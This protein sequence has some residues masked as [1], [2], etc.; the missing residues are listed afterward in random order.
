MTQLTPPQAFHEAQRLIRMGDYPRAAGLTQQLVQNIPDEPAIRGLHGIASARMGLVE[1]GLELLTEACEKATDEKVRPFLLI[2]KAAALRALNRPQD[3]LEACE[4]AKAIDP[5]RPEAIAATAECLIDLGRFD[6]A[7]ALVGSRAENEQPVVVAARARLG[8]LSGKPE[9][10]ADDLAATCE[11]V[12]VA[13]EDLERMLRLLG[14]VRE[15]QGRYD[16]ALKSYKR[17]TKLRRGEFDPR[18]HHAMVN[19]LIANWTPA[20]VGKIQRSSVDGSRAVFLLGVPGAGQEVAEQIIA[21]HPQGFGGGAMLTLPRVAR[22][23]LGAQPKSFRHVVAKPNMLKG[24]QLT[25]GGQGYMARL[26]EYG[27]Q[28]DRVTDSNVLNLYLAGLIPLMLAGTNIVFCTREPAE[29]AFEWWTS[30]PG[31]T[32]PYAQ[33]PTDLADQMGDALRLTAHWKSLL[34]SMGVKTHEF[35]LA[36][37][38]DNSEAEGKALLESVGLGFDARCLEP[39]RHANMRLAPRDVHRLPPAAWAHRYSHF[40]TMLKPGFESIGN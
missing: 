11:Q 7:A 15:Q 34:E 32:H 3:A 4:A 13:A 19:E 31:P 28:G 17:A 18:A 22:A 24:K 23:G 12:G 1:K 9:L 14:E 25:Q 5:Q 16:E 6:E 8:L 40:S 36:R 35:S 37:F 33:D 29:A 26:T 20:A 39:H 2:E 21:S 30:V 38:A 10:G 27:P